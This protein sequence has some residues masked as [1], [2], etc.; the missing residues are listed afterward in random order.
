MAI[1]MNDN[2]LSRCEVVAVTGA[3]GFVGRHLT[4]RLLDLGKEVISIDRADGT[5]AAGLPPYRRT[6]LR[7]YAAARA[8]L[9]GAEI[10]FHLAGNSS[11]T[12]SVLD[13]VFDFRAN[14]LATCN[15]GAAAV[16]NGTRL[17]VYLSTASV[18]GSPQ[19]CPITEDHPTLPYLPYGASKLCGETMLSALCRSAGL[20]V[21]IGRSTTI[22]GPGCDPSVA[23]DEVSQFLRWLLNDRPIPT[24]G[25]PACKTRDFIHVEDVVTGL[26]ALTGGRAD[27]A[28]YNLG[29]GVE[30]SMLDLVDVLGRVTGRTPCLHPDLQV[31][32]DTYRL[33]LD[34]SR[35][36]GLGFAPSI[37]LQDGAQMLAEALG[38]RPQLPSNT[39]VFRSASVVRAEG[40]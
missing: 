35:I 7:D 17:V 11:G 23:A 1:G 4:V 40:G 26:L 5:D 13:P 28:A 37:R 14:A 12:R 38:Q 21:V 16:A 15:V 24:V 10:I 32:D 3:R 29:T 27:A 9:A 31:R 20:P 2:L 34:I 30:T 33:V 36:R 39:P 6:D 22:Y 25:D 8:T 19:D 18:Y